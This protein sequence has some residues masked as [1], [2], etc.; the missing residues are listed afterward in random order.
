M[1]R[2]RPLPSPGSSPRPGCNPAKKT[3]PPSAITVNDVRQPQ[4]GIAPGEPEFFRVVNA[5]ADRYFDLAVDGEQLRL[6]AQDGVPLAD[7]PGGGPEMAPVDHIL[8]A[9]GARAEFVAVGR[10]KP[11]ALRSRAV[12][13][14]KDGD[15]TPAV[16]LATFFNDRHMGGTEMQPASHPPVAYRIPLPPVAARRT[17]RLSESNARHAFYIDD[18]AF[19]LSDQPLIVARAG[20]VEEWTIENDSDEI[21]AF[22]LHQVHFIV[23]DV[24]GVPNRQRFWADTV[25]VPYRRHAADG[26]TS[27]GRVRLL[28]DFRDDVVR[29]TFVFH[30][31]ILD[32]EDGG[33]MAK[34]AVR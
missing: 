32:H 24:D 3:L 31:H 1:K 4:I 15:P 7:A 16:T 18:R 9:P 27:P 11:T 14:G 2:P 29:G 19:K 5:A 28:A 22:H 20:T 26:K 30:C 12:D 17:I 34:I 25:T 8:L 23:E 13:T 10:L 33:M 6:V 21:H